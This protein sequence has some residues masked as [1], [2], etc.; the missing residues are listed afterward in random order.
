VAKANDSGVVHSITTAQEALEAEQS[1]RIRRY[2]IQMGIRTA[3]FVGAVLAS[4]WLRWTMVACAVVIPYLAVIIANA[5]RDKAEYEVPAMT[6]QAPR[7]LTPAKPGAAVIVDPDGP[8]GPDT[9][10]LDDA[11]G[12]S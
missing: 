6:P 8:G 5:G 1:R 9:V 7:E 4:G 12:Q 10:G 3:C 2:A 11:D